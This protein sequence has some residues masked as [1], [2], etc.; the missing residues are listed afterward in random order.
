VVRRKHVSNRD[1]LLGMTEYLPMDSSV[2]HTDQ[3]GQPSFQ[4]MASDLQENTFYVFDSD[5]F[6]ALAQAV[7]DVALE[8]AEGRLWAAIPSSLNFESLRERYWELAATLEEVTVRLGEKKA[9]RN[10]RLR[11]VRG[12]PAL[13]DRFWVVLY[14]GPRVQ[15]LA[16]AEEQSAC[17]DRTAPCFQ[18]FYTFQPTLIAEIRDHLFTLVQAGQGTIDAFQRLR[19]IDFAGKE[20]ETELART[21]QSVQQA[22]LKLQVPTRRYQSSNFAA[23]LEKSLAGLQQF[24]E[25]LPERLARGTSPPSHD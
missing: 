11:F 1:L 21:R 17:S 8:E 24:S 12:G 19:F 6:L 3:H 9:R 4:A 20:L 23:D 25:S 7:E 16:I 18:G 13:L 2:W 5:A 14:E 22:L 15:L 10:G